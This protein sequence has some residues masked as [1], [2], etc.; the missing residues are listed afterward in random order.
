MAGVVVVDLTAKDGVSPVLG[1][2]QAGAKALNSK[3]NTLSGTL[4]RIGTAALVKG[5]V[6][7][8]VEADRTGK[9]LKLLSGSY[10]ETARLQNFAA[11]AARK[12][13]IGQTVWPIAAN[14]YFFK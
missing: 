14:G 4:A 6:S 8:G 3:L 11:E 2:V 1:K 9:R 13:T 12:F 10:G 5:F 7:A